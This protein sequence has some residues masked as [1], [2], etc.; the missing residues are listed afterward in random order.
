MKS[1]VPPVPHRFDHVEIATSE[2]ANT[3]LFFEKLGFCTTQERESDN[4]KQKLMIQGRVRVLLSEGTA[5]TYQHDYVMKNGEGLCAMA[6]HVDSAKKTLNLLKQQKVQ[7]AQ[8]FVTEED[9]V[10]FL[11]SSAV[12]SLADMRVT[13]VT[14]SGAPHDVLSPFA[15]NFK[16]VEP[17]PELAPAGILTF[18]G[19]G[20]FDSSKNQI[21]MIFTCQDVQKTCDLYRARGLKVTTEGMPGVELFAE[22]KATQI[23][24]HFRKS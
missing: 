10:M 14:R 18:S 20:G 4:L 15:P 19:M 21:Q 1:L 6:Y 8:E 22:N 5:G 11:Q 12:H 16:K 2:L 17:R 23:L 24:F 7:V 9:D 3:E 13:F